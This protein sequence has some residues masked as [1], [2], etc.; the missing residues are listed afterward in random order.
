MAMMPAA[1]IPLGAL[2]VTEGILRR[3]AP[4]QVKIAI[5][6]GGIGLG[7][8]GALGLERFSTLHAL[9]LSLFQ[10]AGFAT[11]AWL[12]ATRDRGTLMAS[13]NRSIGRLAVRAPIVI[14]LIATDF[15]VLAPH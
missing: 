6:L 11:C 9:L 8:G 14:P 7:L 2:V 5:V 15:Q 1:L 10:P 13:E 4:R 3:H 12:L